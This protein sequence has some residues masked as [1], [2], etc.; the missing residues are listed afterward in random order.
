MTSAQPQSPGRDAYV[1][2][3]RA[4]SLIVVV[5]WHWA[6]TILYWNGGPRATSPLGFTRGFWL[7]TWLLQVMPLFFYIGGFVHLQSWTR[8]QRRGVGIAP[9]VWRRIRQLAV[10]AGLLL[11]TWLTLGAAAQAYFGWDW[12]GRAVKLVVSPLWFLAVYLMLIALLP[13]ALWLHRRYGMIALIWLA[14]AAMCVDILRFRYGHDGLAW[15]NMVLVWG[16]AHQA[17]FFYATVVEAPRRTDWA[18]LWGGL[19]GLVGLVFSGLYPPSMVGVPGE[20][21]SNMAPPAFVIVALLLFQIGVTELL[22]P[23]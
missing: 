9:F 12:V 20:R 15:I 11:V 13:V 7:A 1:D 23:T 19:F 18:L 8:A 21:F 22:R 5:V 17:G 10:P 4:I 2:W 16:L 3:L 14:G 6:F